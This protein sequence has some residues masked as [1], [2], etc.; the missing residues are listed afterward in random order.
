MSAVTLAGFGLAGAAVGTAG[1]AL[2]L[3]EAKRH[4]GSLRG[5]GARWLCAGSAA[6]AVAVAA[7]GASGDAAT[8]TMAAI[9]VLW[10]FAAALSDIGSRRIRVGINTAALAA[11]TGWVAMSAVVYGSWRQAVVATAVGVGWGII[12]E[13]ISIWRPDG[14]G[15]ADA[16][17]GAWAVTAGVWSIGPEA[18]L[19]LLAVTHAA[20]AAVAL[21]QR[22]RS[23]PFGA[24]LAAFAAA[25][26]AAAGIAA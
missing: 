24:W 10:G 22:R 3:R 2:G 7:A 18:A 9:C 17:T 8:A 14:L 19:A 13:L 6:G 16:R 4:G 1:A 12:M 26:P 20:A 21:A 5:D 11:V 25:C 23:A 15:G